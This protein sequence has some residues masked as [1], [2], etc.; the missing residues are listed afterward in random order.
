VDVGVGVDPA[1]DIWHPQVNAEVLKDG[2]GVAELGPVE[3]TLRLADDHCVE[4]AARCGDG[5]QEPC[6]LGTTPPGKGSAVADVEELLDDRP[7]PLGE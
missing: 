2:E 3:R 4:G 7:V 6:R 5:F 1:A